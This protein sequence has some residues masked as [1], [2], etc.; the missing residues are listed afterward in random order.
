[1][2]HGLLCRIL[3][4]PKMP[5]TTNVLGNLLNC[6]GLGYFDVPKFHEFGVLLISLDSQR[7][8]LHVLHPES[9]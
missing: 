3:H 2:C 5:N 9:C 1:M 7:V 4:G 6:F 8:A